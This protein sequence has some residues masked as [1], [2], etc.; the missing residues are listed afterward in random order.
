M[1]IR[2]GSV[3]CGRVAE[4]ATPATTGRAGEA[5][6]RLDRTFRKAVEERA[7]GREDDASQGHQRG[8]RR[9]LKVG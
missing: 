1:A 8:S 9:F 5:N 3:V 7:L 2:E 6:V 4:V